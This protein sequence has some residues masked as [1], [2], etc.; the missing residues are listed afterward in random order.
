MVFPGENGFESLFFKSSSLLT[1][2]YYLYPLASC[3]FQALVFRYFSS[4]SMLRSKCRR[5]KKVQSLIGL[6]M[7][8]VAT[9]LFARAKYVI[10]NNLVWEKECLFCLTLKSNPF[11]EEIIAM[12]VAWSIHLQGE[13]NG[14]RLCS[15]D[16][17]FSCWSPVWL[18]ANGM[19]LCTFK[20]AISPWLFLTRS[21]PMSIPKGVS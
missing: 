14:G 2:L 12:G 9:A 16:L 8:V 4:T 5:D 1:S 15:T 6:T 17:P 19:M 13:K 7:D 3:P 21:I 20:V 11:C 10:K 18:S